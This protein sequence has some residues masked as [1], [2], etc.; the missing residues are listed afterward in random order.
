MEPLNQLIE[1]IQQKDLLKIEEILK[2]GKIEI[3][4]KIRF[5]S[6]NTLLHLAC[7]QDDN[8]ELIK[9]MFK[10]KSNPN[11]KNN[12][13]ISA[14]QFPWNKNDE[15]MIRLFVENGNEMEQII[16]CLAIGSQTPEFMEYLL[17]KKADPNTAISK[18][19]SEENQDPKMIEFL[20][21]NGASVNT[22]DSKGENIISALL[23]NKKI[24]KD[25]SLLDLMLSK[26]DSKLIQT[27]PLINL[28][29][30]N[31]QLEIEIIQLLIEKKADL[32]LKDKDGNG[33]LLNL[34]K[35]NSAQLKTL[36]LLLENKADPNQSNSEDNQPIHLA[37]IHKK[38]EFINALI[39]H[40]SELNHRNKNNTTPLFISLNDLEIFRILLGNKADPNIQCTTQK[41]TVLHQVVPSNKT[42]KHFFIIFNEISKR[43][44][45]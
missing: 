31:E 6:G 23:I 45:K 34:M 35:N 30:K 24:A 38:K 42:K 11:I 1:F 2:E 13:Q 3:N 14:F 32:N 12:Y 9:L 19:F 33:A 43:F 15:E 5:H 39:S 16:S 4:G 18:L 17:E 37:C 8:K 29:C 27:T 40:K 44:E 20:F 22:L 10:Y 36:E 28:A 25:K 21:K 26:M 41:K 7:T